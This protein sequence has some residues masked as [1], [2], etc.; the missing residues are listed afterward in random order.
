MTKKDEMQEITADDI[1]KMYEPKEDKAQDDGE[2]LIKVDEDVKPNE[3]K[4]K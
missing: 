4:E 1:A 2:D 3:E